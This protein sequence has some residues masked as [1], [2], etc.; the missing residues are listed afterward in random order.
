[1]ENVVW[2]IDKGDPRPLYYQVKGMLRENILRGTWKPGE[3]LPTEESFCKRL[4]V[5][6]VTVGRAINDLVAEGLIV[7]VQ[8]KGTYVADLDTKINEDSKTI[9][10]VL[11]RTEVNA[12]SYFNDVMR[13][14]DD[15]ARDLDYRIL[16][17]T[18]NSQTPEIEEGY[19]C[20]KEVMDKELGGLLITAEQIK[21][22]ELNKLKENKVP[23]VV[24]NYAPTFGNWV[25]V[26]W[27]SGSYEA[28]K[29]LL[30]Q[31]HERIAYL[32]GMVEKFE[33]D[34]HKFAGFKKAIFEAGLSFDPNLLKQCPYTERDR[35]R[36]L[37]EE[38]LSQSPRPTAIFCG[39]DII[40]TKVLQIAQK[41]NLK[42]PDD[43][44]I[45]GYGNLPITTR[46][47]PELTTVD[48]PRYE[49]GRQAMSI[50]AKLK[51]GAEEEQQNVLM[52]TRL[53]IRN[54]T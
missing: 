21:N 11:H 34:K 45:I 5:S 17:L 15:V 42:V 14:I 8:G 41:S 43:L 30:S 24:L 52:P 33:V 29:H 10:L 22:V 6:R 7:R 32:G 19:F 27:A 48:V 12:D 40:A 4:G 18:F 2:K 38:L 49:L 20:L 50:F 36:P 25:T 23:F 44:A 47:H 39:D 53:I 35:I 51:S 54:S 37:V 16:L 13:G 26:D 46:L 1:M 31:G 28:V 3:L 9:G